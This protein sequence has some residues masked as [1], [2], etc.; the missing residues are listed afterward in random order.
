MVRSDTSLWW[1]LSF[2]RL[3]L[4]GPP[5][6]HL[7]TTLELLTSHKLKNGGWK[8]G[9]TFSMEPFSGA[10]TAGATLLLLSEATLTE[11]REEKEQRAAA[12]AE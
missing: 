2:S 5:F 6:A 4:D 10:R 12:L 3:N 1:S 8:H 7:V 11:V 9:S